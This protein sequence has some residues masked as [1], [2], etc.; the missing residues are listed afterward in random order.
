VSLLLSLPV[1]AL[2]FDSFDCVG[3]NSSWHL[4]L[5]DKKFTFTHKSMPKII[6]TPVKQEPAENMDI[7]HIRVF[8][9]N[10][11]KKDAIIIIQKQSCTD[12]QSEDLFAY[13]GLFITSDKVFHGCCSKTMLLTH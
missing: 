5:N 13:E 12:G 3:T 6:M 11:N 2:A 7:D 10:I 4:S 9:T 1:P 8:R